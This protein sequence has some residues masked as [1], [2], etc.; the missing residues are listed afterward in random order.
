MGRTQKITSVVEQNEPADLVYE[1]KITFEA[2]DL[3]Y[4]EALRSLV[5][6]FSGRFMVSYRQ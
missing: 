2:S 1:M 4:G 3:R 6:R 5:T